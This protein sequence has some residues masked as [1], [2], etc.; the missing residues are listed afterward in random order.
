M[1]FGLVITCYVHVR[2]VPEPVCQT[3]SG[4]LVAE[5]VDQCL[6]AATMMAR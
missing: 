6:W 1:P 5:Y 2:L 3:T 4:K